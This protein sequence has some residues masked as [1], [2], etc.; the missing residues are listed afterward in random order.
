M[1][2]IFVYETLSGG[3]QLA[4]ADGETAS[5]DL[6]AAGLSMR[7]AVVADLLRLIE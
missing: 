5:D 7:N 6:F 4:E 2:R 3:G 1:K